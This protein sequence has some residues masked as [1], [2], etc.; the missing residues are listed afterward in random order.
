[1]SKFLR[2]ASWTTLSC[3]L[4]LSGCIATDNATVEG[5]GTPDVTA[6]STIPGVADGADFEPQTAVTH[7]LDGRTHPDLFYIAW[8]QLDDRTDLR[9][10]ADGYDDVGFEDKLLVSRRSPEGEYNTWQIWPKLDSDCQDQEKVRIH[11]FDVAPDGKSLFVS[12][13]REETDNPS[14]KLG[15]YKLDIASQSITK[16]SKDNSVD[17]LN[18]TYV[19]NDPTTSNEILMI[20][21]TVQDTE[22]TINYRANKLLLDEYDRS[23]T[24]LIHKMDAQTGDLTLIGF[25]NSHQTEPMVMDGPDGNKLIVFN[26][27]EHQ[28]TTNRF[29]LWKMQIDGSD[30]FT[31][32]GQESATDRSSD[33][34]YS[35]RL[36]RSGPYK[37]YVLMGQGARSNHSFVAE[38]D[39]VM[40]HRAHLDLRSTRIYLQELDSSSGVDQ[41]ISRAPEHY[42]DESFTYSYRLG[43]D[44]SYALY[45]KDFPTSADATLDNTPGTE[46]ISNNNYHFMQPRSFYPP[47]STQVAPSDGDIGESRVSFTN[48]NLN[49]N[50]GFLVQNIGQSDNG[51]QHQ[52]DNIPPEDLSL[53]FHI[54]SHHFSDSNAVGLKSSQ[55][56]SIPASGFIKPESD[57]SIGVVLKNGLYVWKMNK[58]FEHTDASGNKNDLWIPVRAERQEINFVPNRVN[59]CNQCHQERNQANLDKYADY[60]SIAATKMTGDL[61]NV[62]GTDKDISSYDASYSVPD[63]HND[64]MPLFTKASASGGKACADCHNAND[65]L[66]LSNETGISVNNSTFMNLVRGAH[67]LSDNSGVV[68]F[69]SDSIN[70]LGMDDNYTPAPFL[71]SL[72]LN[73]DLT[74]PASGS[75]GNTSSRDLDREGDYG[76]A[77]NATVEADINSINSQYDHSKHWDTEDLQSFI[78]YT[79]TQIPV[80]LSDRITFASTSQSITTPQAQKAYQAMVRNCFSC[81]TNNTDDGID[82]EGFGL[83]KNKRFISD[84]WLRDRDMRFVVHRHLLNKNDTAY[85]Y[86]TWVSNL[87]NS[88][89]NTLKGARHRIN[90][91]DKLNS[92]L[93][94]YARGGLAADGSAGTLNDSVGPHPTLDVNSEDYLAIAKWVTGQAAADGEIVNQPPVINQSINEIVINEYADPAELDELITWSDPDTDSN[95][96]EELSQA[97]ISGSG[98]STHAFNDTMLALTYQDL[99]SAKLKTYAILGDRGD[100]NFTFRVTDGLINSEVQTLAV[101]VESD[102]NVPAPSSDMPDAFAFYTDRATGELRKLETNGGET[103]VGT[104]ENYNGATWTTMYRRADKQWLYFVEQSSQKIHVVDETNADYLFS[105]TLNHE[106]NKDSDTH[107]QTVYLIWWQPAEGVEGEDDYRAGKLQGLLESKLSKHKNGDWYVNLGDGEMPTDSV[108]PIYS[109]KLNDGGNTVGVYTWRRATF[110][111]KW[112]NTATDNEGLDRINVLN[113]ETGKAKPLASYAFEAKNVNGVDYEAR[114]YVNVRA[115]AIAEN[116]AFYGFNKDLNQPVEVFNFDPLAGIQKPVT[117]IPTWI[118]DLLNDPVSYATPFLVVPPKP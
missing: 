74:V 115:I 37:N 23:P 54:P 80:G 40:T 49:G 85:D 89:S 82:D 98:T 36:I 38:G 44:N 25:N 71:W 99:K 31:F 114:N 109:T 67:K 111:T 78:T 105:I 55:E 65:K 51:V 30:S 97:F 35:P 42:N 76:A 59:A 68:P 94:V 32:Y 75:Y 20:A 60:T 26:Q 3:A 86:R 66:N 81:H 16:L 27:W 5:T 70:P 19:G 91:A 12:M 4:F 95:G 84:T 13:S 57:G 11:S 63:F 14:R 17:F 107:K 72:L 77:Y 56:A 79:T 52:L 110:M 106:P 6:C 18:P 8:A 9:F 21:K 33:N 69:V 28:E 88:M 116:G 7:G 50:A 2:P 24:P 34:L 100:Q 104:I 117:N 64:I 53:Q 96:N 22:L 103:I 62:L 15:I 93:L 43:S 108:R 46:I 47:E 73:D 45:I 61:T 112:N 29:A 39:I 48:N 58:R 41:H 92:E 113:L 90:F 10:P 101:R 87:T 1:M 83:P 118:N 102:Y